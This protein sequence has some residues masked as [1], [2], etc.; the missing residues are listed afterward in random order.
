MAT[1]LLMRAMLNFVPPLFGQEMFSQVVAQ[2]SRS[3]KDSFIHLESRLLKIADVHIHRHIMTAEFYPS[4]AQ[5]EPFKPQFELLLQEVLT[6]MQ[7][8]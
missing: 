4:S 8:G 7:A 2:T 6:R 3:L 1:T 5:V